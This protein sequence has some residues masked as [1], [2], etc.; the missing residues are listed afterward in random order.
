MTALTLLFV[1]LGVALA[2]PVYAFGVRR[3][4]GLR[5]SPLRALLGGIIAFACASPIITAIGASIVKHNGSWPFLP[6]LWFVILGV[7]IALLVTDD[8]V[9]L[10]PC[11]DDLPSRDVLLEARM[12][13]VLESDLD[14][15]L[16]PDFVQQFDLEHG[17]SGPRFSRYA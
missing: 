3:M 16:P 11:A 2:V 12:W 1:V 9:A 4:L 7:A 13:P 15:A 14:L 5:L 8:S 10:G 6:A 17:T